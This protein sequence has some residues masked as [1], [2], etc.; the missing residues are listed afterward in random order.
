MKRIPEPELMNDY[1]QAEAYASADFEN[2]NKLFLELFNEKFPRHKGT[3]NMLDL[4]C[5]PGNIM[6]RFA[7]SFPKMNIHGV[8]GAEEMM[9]YGEQII[10]KN[11]ALKQRIKFIKGFIPGVKLPIEKY[12]TIISNSLLHHLHEPLYFWQAVKKFSK[13]ESAVLLMDLRRPESKEAARKLVDQYSATEPTVLRMD[14]Y[15]SLLAA[16]EPDEIKWQLK[17]ENL[18]YLNVDIVSDRHV[19]VWG[20]IK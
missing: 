19:L 11:A 5:G 8:D 20:V 7:R 9:A 1:E 4:G 10:E 12:D 16:F 18:D 14:F 2:S 13:S 15:N 3:G 6:L 17:Q